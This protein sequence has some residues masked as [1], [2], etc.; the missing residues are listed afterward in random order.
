MKNREKNS[1]ETPLLFQIGILFFICLVGEWIA[2][3][4]PIPFPGSVAAMLLLFLLLITGL[5]KAERIQKI[6]DFMLSNMSFFFI[7]AGISILEYV[8]LIKGNVLALILICAVSLVITFAATAFTVRLVFALQKKWS[9]R[10]HKD[11]SLS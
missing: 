1:K 2:N 7:P 4:L 10:E 6:A 11:G 8:G 5:L 9:R 3:I